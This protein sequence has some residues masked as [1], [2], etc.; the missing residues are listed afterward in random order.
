[1]SIRR[2]NWF[3]HLPAHLLAYLLMLVLLLTQGQLL[4]SRRLLVLLV[5]FRMPSAGPVLGAVLDYTWSK[6]ANEEL[7]EASCM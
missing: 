3:F 1:M 4:L 6:A 5:V 2:A 7:N